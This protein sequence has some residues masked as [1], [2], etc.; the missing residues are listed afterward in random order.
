MEDCSSL[1]FSSRIE[2]AD[3]SELAAIDA[4]N[5]DDET[6]VHRRARE[7]LAAEKAATPVMMC[8][9]RR[10]EKIRK[11]DVMSSRPLGRVAAS[12]RELS[13]GEEA[14]VTIRFA[15][16]AARIDSVAAEDGGVADDGR[17]KVRKLLAI[18]RC[19]HLHDFIRIERAGA[20]GFAKPQIK[21]EAQHQVSRS[22]NSK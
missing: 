5:A 17:T 19:S 22:V 7:C 13:N 2:D 8:T 3:D 21:E 9:P 15:L 4:F 20:V 12:N 10:T 16:R 11:K 18:A 6:V 14:K 1:A